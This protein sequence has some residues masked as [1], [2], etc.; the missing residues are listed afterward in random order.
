M[1]TDNGHGIITRCGNPAFGDF[2]CNNS[3]AIAKYF[4]TFSNFT[5]EKK[6]IFE[7]MKK[8]N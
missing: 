1:Y 2:Q 5:G 3:L 6:L 8:N 4:K 7:K